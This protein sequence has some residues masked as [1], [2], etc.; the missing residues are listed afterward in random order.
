MWD[1]GLSEVPIAIVNRGQAS[2]DATVQWPKLS[3]L[4]TYFI[5]IVGSSSSHVQYET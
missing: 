3:N 5:L 1:I 4:G 2:Y